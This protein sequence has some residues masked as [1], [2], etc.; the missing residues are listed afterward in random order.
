MIPISRMAEGCREIAS[1]WIEAVQLE[2]F[3]ESAKLDLVVV[4]NLLAVHR[5]AK[6]RPGRR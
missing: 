3:D 1:H 5:E 4:R 6:R 2:K